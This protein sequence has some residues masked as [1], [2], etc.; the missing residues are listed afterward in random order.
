MY[1]VLDNEVSK[2][3]MASI[4]QDRL[5]ESRGLE[6]RSRIVVRRQHERQASVAKQW[7]D[8]GQVAVQG[9]DTDAGPPPQPG[10]QDHSSV[11]KVCSTSPCGLC[12]PEQNTSRLASVREGV[13]ETVPDNGAS[14]GG[15]YGHQQIKPGPSL[16]RSVS[17]PGSISH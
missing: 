7:Y 8:K 1:E 9:G 10:Y 2:Q 11:H 4:C 14:P 15:P 12:E 13:T 5:A 6:E 17:G 16:L 3:P